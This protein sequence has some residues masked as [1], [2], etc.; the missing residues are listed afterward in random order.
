MPGAKCRHFQINQLAKLARLTRRPCPH[1]LWIQYK[2]PDHFGAQRNS[3]VGGITATR[4]FPRHGEQET[5]GGLMGK[6]SGSCDFP[7]LLWGTP[8]PHPYPPGRRRRGG[9]FTAVLIFFK[10]IINLQN[11]AALNLAAFS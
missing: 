4:L 8:H 1:R 2:L 6:G 5:L 11:R 3:T 7:D 10:N 9:V